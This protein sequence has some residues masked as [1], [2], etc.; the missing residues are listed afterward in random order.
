[1]KIQN[2]PASA[3][4]ADE[5][6]DGF[7]SEGAK[8]IRAFTVKDSVPLDERYLFVRGSLFLRGR[9]RRMKCQTSSFGEDLIKG[10]RK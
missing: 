8:F 2:H 6:L 10:N 5:K 3:N 4:L 7:C 1:V 9:A